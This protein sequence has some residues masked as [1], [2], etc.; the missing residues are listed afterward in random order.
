MGRRHGPADRYGAELADHRSTRHPA[1]HGPGRYPHGHSAP[2]EPVR[3]PPHRPA[4]W[5]STRGFVGGE[6]DNHTD[7]T[8][9]GARDYDPYTGLFVSVDPVLDPADLQSLNAYNYAS[10]NPTTLS[11]PTGLRP[12][13]EEDGCVD[14]GS[15]STEPG[16]WSASGGPT[17]EEQ[18]SN[19]GGGNAGSRHRGDRH[20]TGGTRTARLPAAIADF[21]SITR[22]LLDWIRNSSTGSDADL[23]AVA[24]T[25]CGLRMLGMCGGGGSLGRIP[26][27]VSSGGFF[28]VLRDYFGR[29]L[30]KTP[31]RAP[32]AGA[33]TKPWLRGT[34]GNAGRVPDSVNTALSGR[35]FNSWKEFRGEF[36]RAVSADPA[37]AG[38]FSAS[39]QRQM[40]QGLAPFVHPGQRYGGRLRYE[41]HHVT[42][43]S[44]GGGEF[45]LDNIVVSTPRYHAEI[46]DPRYHYGGGR[47]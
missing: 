27:E 42:P 44:R 10:N 35:K 38:Q 7:L 22:S 2:R 32:E 20:S 23:L 47:R 16:G 26:S 11:D 39:N 36:W 14:C 46:L 28:S 1:D 9:L 3:P 15:R 8:H 17:P 24:P 18:R 33:A 5:P 4:T 25:S 37:L 40:S 19:N 13:T 21:S 6:T 41:L 29:L 12:M 30:G 34:H 45:D 31:K 43:R